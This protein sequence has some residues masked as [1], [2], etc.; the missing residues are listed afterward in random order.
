MNPDVHV[1][2][3]ENLAQRG[4]IA[5]TT[6]LVTPKSESAF[7][8]VDGME[9]TATHPAGQANMVFTATRTVLHVFMVGNECK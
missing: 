2:S 8:R 3:M 6:D 7:A 5:R 9:Q 4:A 1:A